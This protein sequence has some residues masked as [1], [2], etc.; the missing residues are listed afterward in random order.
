[1]E[2]KDFYLHILKENK[3]SMSSDEMIDW[4]LNKKLSSGIGEIDY[5][6][7]KHIAR[8]SDKWELKTFDNPSVFGKWRFPPKDKVRNVPIIAIEYEGGK[9]EVLDGKH[10]VA[11]HNFLNLPIQAWIGK[12]FSLTER[13]EDVPKFLKRNTDGGEVDGVI[14][15][16]QERIKNWFDIGKID[17][18]KGYENYS[19]VAFLNNLYVDE[20][21]RGYGVGT[22][23]L[24]WFIEESI[25][26]GADAIYL[27]SDENN[28]NSMN[29][30]DWY[31]K[32][33]F[34]PAG[35][36]RAGETLLIY[37]NEI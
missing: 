21:E 22:N 19:K 25:D 10:R 11:E 12:H 6:E 29:L 35:W 16:N 33:G 8:H 31:T 17:G 18:Y 37:K 26:L 9:Y 24:D 20:D 34:E 14:H 27:I 30:T 15:G 36:S 1:M 2:Y 13:I 28:E 7:A 5:D 3:A 23:L 32:R 4:I